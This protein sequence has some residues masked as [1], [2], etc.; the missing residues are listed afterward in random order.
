MIERHLEDRRMGARR[1]DGGCFLDPLPLDIG[2]ERF[3]GERSE[4][5]VKMKGRKRRDPGQLGEGQRLAQPPADVVDDAIDALLVL[6]S[7][8]V[9]PA[10]IA[11]PSPAP[12]P[13]PRFRGG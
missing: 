4:D 7:R 12:S 6:G 8:G 10:I 9:R 11:A 5:T 13:S 1:E 2:E 3:A